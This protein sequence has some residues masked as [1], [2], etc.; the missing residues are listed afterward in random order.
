[1]HVEV[2]HPEG[3]RLQWQVKCVGI[4][5]YAQDD[6]AEPLFFSEHITHAPNQSTHTAQLLFNVFVTAVDVIDAIKNR[7][8]VCDQ[9]REN[10]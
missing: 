2:F 4:L 8:A 9:R 7:F 6:S 1:M 5:R 3:S 10:Q